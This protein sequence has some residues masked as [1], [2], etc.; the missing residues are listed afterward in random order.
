MNAQR[1]RPALHANAGL[2]IFS[3]SLVRLPVS[4]SRMIGGADKKLDRRWSGLEVRMHDRETVEAFLAARA[5][6]LSVLEAAGEAGVG[7]GTAFDWD[8]GVLPHSYTGVP[9]KR[10]P[11][12]LEWPGWPRRSH[13]RHPWTSRKGVRCRDGGERP[14]RGGVGRPKRGRLAPGFNVE[15]EKVRA[16]REIGAG[17]RPALPPGHRF[18]EDLEELP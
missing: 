11:G 17:D 4:D 8:A 15:R 10:P 5:R 9:A 7:C 2:S 6:G 3:H 18:L 16:R 1:C 14:A 12:G 13:G